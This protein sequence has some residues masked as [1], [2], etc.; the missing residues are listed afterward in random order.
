MYCGLSP[1]S[2]MSVTLR[3]ILAR[4]LRRQ[5][6]NCG[7]PLVFGRGMRIVEHCPQCGMR[8]WRDGF[9]LGALVVNYT[10]TVFGLLLIVAL[11]TLRGWLAPRF[12]IGLSLG[13][14]IIF[15]WLFYKWSWS[16]WLAS[17]YGVLP[18]ELPANSGGDE[19]DLRQ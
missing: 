16:F 2:P 6:P 12:A 5:C 8:W 19:P 1:L 17:Y 9:Y 11:A 10:V 7:G 15:P 13:I 18:G 14:A 3:Q 4:G